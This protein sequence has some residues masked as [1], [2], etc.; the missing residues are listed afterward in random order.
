M[1]DRVQDLAAT[2][3][4]NFERWQELV[5]K[6]NESTPIPATRQRQSSIKAVTRTSSWQEQ[7]LS[8]PQSV[9]SVTNPPRP[10]STTGTVLPEAISTQTASTV[11]PDRNGKAAAIAQEPLGT[12]AL[13]HD[14]SDAATRGGCPPKGA[15][16]VRTYNELRELLSAFAADHIPLLVI[17]ARPGLGKSRLA[18]EAVRNKQAIII[19]LRKSALDLFTDL[20]RTK[21]RQ[22]ILDD[23][24]DL[25][26]NRLCREIV[27]ALTETDPY[28]RLDW[29]TKTKI[30]EEEGVPKFFWTTSPVCLITNH[31]NSHDP[32]FNAL[33]S[34]AE[35]VYFDPDWVEVYREAGT[36]FWDREIFDYVRNRLRDLKAPDMRLFVKAYNRKKAKLPTMN[37]AS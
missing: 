10:P 29:G 6:T 23:D 14:F 26:S 15:T 31:W 8:T 1:Q 22:V 19:K 13:S 3:W 17:V 35:F 5:G 2:P 34:R 9:S 16:I 30:L 7:S 18:R 11:P 36:W 32:I 25:M 33:E 27:K 24:D 37:C 4:I 28:R 20:F 12:V 21:D